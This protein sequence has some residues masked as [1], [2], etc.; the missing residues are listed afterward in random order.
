M[1]PVS[2]KYETQDAG[3][4]SHLL[5]LVDLCLLAILFVAPLVLGGRHPAGCLVFVSIVAVMSMAWFSRQCLLRQP[6]WRPSAGYWVFLGGIFLVLFQIFPLPA[7][8]IAQLSPNAQSLL[9]LWSVADD[10]EANFGSWNTISMYPGMTIQRLALLVAYGL[11]FVVVVQRV[12]SLADVKK[13]LTWIALATVGMA[14]LGLA[15]YLTANGKFLWTYEHPQREARFVQGP[16]SNRN[17]FVHLLALGI[18]PLVWCFV[19]RM[20]IYDRKQSHPRGQNVFRLRNKPLESPVFTV[21]IGIAVGIVGFTAILATSRGGTLALAA[22]LAIIGIIYGWAKILDRRHAISLL[23]F[24]LIGIAVFAIHGAEQIGDRWDKVQEMSLDSIE[25]GRLRM[26]LWKANSN[27]FMQSPWFGHGV[28]AHREYYKMFLPDIYTVEFTHAEN[29]Y[30]QIASETGLAGLAF[31]GIAVGLCLF[32]C[33][34]ALGRQKE[35]TEVACVGAV[36][37]ALMASAVHSLVDFVWSIP[38]CMSWTVVLCALACRLY[39]LSGNCKREPL[40]Y[41]VS[42]VTWLFATPV[43]AVAGIWMASIFWDPAMASAHWDRYLKYANERVALE[44]E[45]KLFANDPQ[46]Q[47]ELQRV[48]DVLDNNLEQALRAYSMKHLGNAR[49]NLRLA[50]IYLQQ[51]QIHQRSSK[52]PMDVGQIRDAAI[53]SQFPS[54]SA[55]NEWLN[56][57]IGDHRNLLDRALWHAH[58]S[59]AQC[60]LQGEGYLFL[61]ELCFLEGGTDLDKSRYIEQA[62]LVRPHDGSVL[63]MAGKEAA[64][65]GDVAKAIDYWKQSF[66]CGIENK[67]SILYLL[68]SRIPAEALIEMLEP[69]LEDWPLFIYRYNQL[70]NTPQLK[71]VCDYFYVLAQQ[72]ED[73]MDLCD[74]WHNLSRQYSRVEEIE[75][76]VSCAMRALK[77]NSGRFDVRMQLATLLIQLEKFADAEAHLRWCVSRNPDSDHAKTLLAKAVKQRVARSNR[78]AEVSSPRKKFN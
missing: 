12:Q 15:Q 40:P 71:I 29:G 28:G 14:I 64:V 4:P 55:L 2:A 61:A 52:N 36:A 39:Q 68:S 42:R 51:F 48:A 37:A 69:Q 43:I 8:F 58:Q 11:T 41:P 38:A 13:L 63:L 44:Q 19:N 34:V 35:L 18:G 5:H 60:P 76:A 70:R 75:K 3:L 10:A 57:A 7:D 26:E 67:K 74:I 56:R 17:H 59:V 24:S 50:A 77:S 9:P 22:A 45:K 78:D 46:K 72:Q 62:L 20:K 27:A 54:R 32:W 49:V 1:S 16:F 31:L 65:A 23:V 25:S 66:R 53:A 73:S 33:V 6:F 21:I 30:L 47:L